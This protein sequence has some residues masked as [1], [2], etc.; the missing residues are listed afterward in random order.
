MILFS[1]VTLGETTQ[2]LLGI[3]IAPGAFFF[4]AVFFLNFLAR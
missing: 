1:E 2:D 3:L 4:V